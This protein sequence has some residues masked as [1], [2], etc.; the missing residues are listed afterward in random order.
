MRIKKQGFYRIHKIDI[1]QSKNAK[2]FDVEIRNVDAF[3]Y[4]IIY[5]MRHAPFV[6]ENPS[7]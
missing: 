2:K 7:V 1:L 3:I 6:G 4:K 5:T